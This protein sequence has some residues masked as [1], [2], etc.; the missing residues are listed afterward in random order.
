M[1]LAKRTWLR[2]PRHRPLTADCHGRVEWRS[3]YSIHWLK[4]WSRVSQGCSH[5]R[6]RAAG[7]FF[8]RPSDGRQPRLEVLLYYL[9]V[10]A[11]FVANVMRIHSAHRNQIIMGLCDA[12]N[13]LC[14]LSS[15]KALLAVGLVSCQPGRYFLDEQ[16]RCE[17][18]AI[19][20]V[21]CSLVKPV[22]RCKHLHT[23]QPTWR[24]F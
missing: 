23:S 13:T 10:L 20:G 5:L 2:L 14:E 16:V 18:G 8:I 4:V 21:S 1:T 6:R 17:C 24:P 12:P 19:L 7:V 9:R 3:Q 11:I 15:A 22:K